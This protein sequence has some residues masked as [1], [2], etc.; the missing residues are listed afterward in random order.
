MESLSLNLHPGIQVLHLPAGAV[1]IQRDDLIHPVISGNKW[2]KLVG[3]LMQLKNEEKSV[4]VT[5]GGAFSN[6]LVATAVAAQD[7]GLR[8]IGILRGEEK[9]SNHYLDIAERAGMELVGVSRSLY[10]DKTLSLQW[11]LNQLSL[12]AEEVFVVDE[13]GRGPL[14][15][16]G[17]D[18]LVSDWLALDISVQHI[19]HAS[20]TATTAVGLRKAM[21]AAGM[22]AEIHAVMVLKNLEE[23]LSFAAAHGVEAAEELGL[24]R[25]EDVSADT[26]LA[27][28][29]GHEFGGYAKSDVELEALV[30]WVSLRNNIPFESVYTGKALYALNEWLI[31]QKELVQGLDDVSG[32]IYPVM[33]LHTGGTLNYSGV[34]LPVNES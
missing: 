4:L 16:V 5:F 3:H 1:W 12:L 23:Q 33:F 18:A 15:F 20:A 19:F 25:Q 8:C 22:K 29:S 27:F 26:N 2:R 14:G 17:F 11:V 7:A 6:H 10:R 9:I 34:T 28:V 30:Q 13:G 24:S 31:A 32:G 21:D